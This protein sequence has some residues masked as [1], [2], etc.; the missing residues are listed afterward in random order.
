M[1]SI[2]G[3]S[4]TLGFSN[5]EVELGVCFVNGTCINDYTGSVA[6]ASF[7]ISI[8]NVNA[9]E[10]YGNTHEYLSLSVNG[11][12]DTTSLPSY[13]YVYL[14]TLSLSLD[15]AKC[16]IDV[17]AS[18]YDLVTM[19]SVSLSYFYNLT[20]N[21]GLNCTQLMSLPNITSISLTMIPSN[22]L[23]QQSTPQNPN[24]GV[25]YVYNATTIVYDLWVSPT[26]TTSYYI[27]ITISYNFESID[28]Y[29]VVPK[30][31]RERFFLRGFAPTPLPMPS[32]SCPTAPTTWFTWA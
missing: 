22:I 29:N 12:T 6:G 24:N 9:A 10:T 25:Y 31:Y 13:Y 18:I 5:V 8:G 14:L 3:T 4:F 16:G 21:D 2:P 11:N 20:S 28:K 17:N 7:P 32:F 1:T 27:P 15:L 23:L 26:P 30:Q 19:S